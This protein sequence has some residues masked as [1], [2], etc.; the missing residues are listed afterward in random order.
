MSLTNETVQN[1][2]R[3]SISIAEAKYGRP[4]CV[5]VCDQHGFL[6]GF[7]RMEGAPI[8][9]VAISQ[10]KAYTAVRM[11]TSTQAFYERLQR[12]NL[13]IQFFADSQMTALPGGIVIVNSKGEM[14]GGIGVSA[15]APAE[16]QDIVETVVKKIME[17]EIPAEALTK[18]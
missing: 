4:I 8:R 3:L 16:D 1:M 13:Q 11:G 6:R 9:S 18:K 2:L 15:L 7:F 17:G 12:E 10:S 5:S 14:V